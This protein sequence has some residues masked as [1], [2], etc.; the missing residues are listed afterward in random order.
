M[1]WPFATLRSAVVRPSVVP[2][3]ATTEAAWQLGGHLP[4]LAPDR[5]PAAVLLPGDQRALRLG[6]GMDFEQLRPYQPGEPA[7]RI[8]WRI[9]AR[10]QTPM[11]RVFREPAQRQCHL[12]LDTGRSMFF[13]TRQQL[14]ISQALLAGQLL[15]AAALQHNLSVSLHTPGLAE[16]PCRHPS[17]HRAPLLHRWQEIGASL[18]AAD[19]RTAG[20]DAGQGA[21]QIAG[22]MAG[23]TEPDW[24]GYRGRL[25][26]QLPPGQVLIVLGDFLHD[27]AADADLMA[28]VPLAS[29][30]RILWISLYDPAEQQLPD[31][32]RVSFV[33]EPQAHRLNT[34]DPAVRARIADQFAAKQAALT[35]LAQSTHGV[36]LAVSTAWSIDTL[37]ARLNDALTEAA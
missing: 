37:L 13:G 31:M 10:G 36:H 21:G 19:A 3:T 32:G 12:V 7:S 18:D 34:H 6:Q 11:V 8:D 35:A 29:R 26:Q 2:P 4:E 25:Y 22:Q 14:K 9:S 30:H 24:S 16:L 15:T 28:W 23:Q 27:F 17:A 1:R 5:L 20:Q 33:G